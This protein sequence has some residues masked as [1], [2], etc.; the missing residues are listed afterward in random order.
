[1]YCWRGARAHGEGGALMGNVVT[2]H[3][4]SLQEI[5]MQDSE[6]SGNLSQGE[7]PEETVI[8]FSC[9]PAD[10]FSSLS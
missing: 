8:T 3:S 2:Y 10:K 5:H 9:A 7:T 4:G 1:M 6:K